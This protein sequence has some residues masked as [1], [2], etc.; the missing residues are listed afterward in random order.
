MSEPLTRISCLN[1][2]QQ[3]PHESI[4]N[5][6]IRKCVARDNYSFQKRNGTNVAMMTNINN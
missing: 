4:T 2:N 1:T 3:Q 5:L 6:P